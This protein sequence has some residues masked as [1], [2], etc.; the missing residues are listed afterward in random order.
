MSYWYGGALGRSVYGLMLNGSSGIGASS[1]AG[2][3][4]GIGENFGCGFGRSV[5]GSIP[6]FGAGSHLVTMLN[7]ATKISLRLKP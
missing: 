5:Y 3:S 7:F 4:S 2:A 1:G 6:K